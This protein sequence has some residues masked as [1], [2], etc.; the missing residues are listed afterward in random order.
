MIEKITAGVDWLSVSMPNTA[1][2]YH[3]WRRKCHE[4]IEGISNE[5]YRL[6]SRGLL[7]YV[8]LSA[9]NCFI[10]ENQYGSFCQV[11][12]E[13][14][15]TWFDYVYHRDCKVSR[16]DAQI[17]TKL[18]VMDKNIAKEAYRNATLENKTLPAARRRKL[19]IIVGSDG[20]DTFYLGSTSSE[21]RARIYNKE[22]QS[23]DI[24]Y[25]RCWRYEVVLRNELAKQF[26]TEYRQRGDRRPAFVVSF[27][28][29]WFGV[30]GVDISG[31]SGVEAVILPLERTRPTDIER[32]LEWIGTQVAPTIR[33]LIAEGYRDT[34]L[35]LLELG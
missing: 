22:V 33:Y 34:I 19:W 23:E 13:K 35:A 4:A 6:E 8:G 21:Q 32:K 29:R 3:E 1:P 20:G 18:E 17:T 28:S 27:V 15:Q 9:G 7:G 2:E 30:R 10:G 14:A 24:Q 25:T 31:L 11:T 16:I 12:G 5:G 26:T